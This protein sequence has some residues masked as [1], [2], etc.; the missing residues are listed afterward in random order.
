MRIPLFV[1]IFL[2]AVV[3]VACATIPI[4][5]Y[6]I[7]TSQSFSLDYT[8]KG[9]FVGNDDH[10]IINANGHVVLTRRTGRTE[11][12]LD[13]ASQKQIG[14]AFQTAGFAKKR[15]RDGAAPLLHRLRD[16]AG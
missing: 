16:V 15:S 8:R 4:Q 13:N 3:L 2:F 12:D 10:L 7:A 5:P 14:D 1:V 9:G 11:F 6:P